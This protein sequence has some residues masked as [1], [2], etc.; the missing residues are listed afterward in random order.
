[1][2]FN[3]L[4]AR[5]HFV[6]A[7]Y[8]SPF[9]GP[10]KVERRSLLWSSPVILNKVPQISEITNLVEYFEVSMDVSNTI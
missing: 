4:K 6:E 3:W 7:V 1:M 9:Y 10:Q 5:R 2:G 8:F